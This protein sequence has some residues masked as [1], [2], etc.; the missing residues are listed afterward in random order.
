MKTF[1]TY[2]AKT[3]LSKLIAA[4]QDGDE[5]VITKSGQPAALLTGY[6]PVKTRTPGTMAGEI[7]I[8]SDFDELP[9]TFMNYF[10]PAS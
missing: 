4:V 7:M 10:T 1:S 3:H 2:E 6:K 8:Q 5:I 9:D